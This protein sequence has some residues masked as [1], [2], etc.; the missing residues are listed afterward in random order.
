MR[1]WPNQLTLRAALAPLC[2]RQTYKPPPTLSVPSLDDLGADVP[3]NLHERLALVAR[4]QLAEY[5]QDAS[6]SRGRAA[7][8]S[9]GEL[10]CVCCCSCEGAWRWRRS[11]SSQQ[12]GF[13]QETTSRRS[14]PLACRCEH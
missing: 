1:R 3:R 14:A 9:L 12:P 5:L 7:V 4:L 2:Q 10:C 8:G 11:L 13:N 6:V